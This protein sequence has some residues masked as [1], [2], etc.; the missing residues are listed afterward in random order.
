VKAAHHLAQM[1]SMVNETNTMATYS[2][3][4]F[5]GYAVKMSAH[6]AK[7]LAAHKDVKYIEPNMVARALQCQTFSPPNSWG[8]ARTVIQGPIP[9]SPP[10]AQQP[11]QLR[12]PGADGQG[13]VVHVIDTGI[14]CEHEDFAGGRCTFGFDS[15]REGFFDGNGH[16][17]HV[18]S[19]AVG[20]RFGLARSAT[21]V[22]V[23]VLGSNGSGTF[24]GV[25][26]GIN[27]SA[28]RARTQRVVGNMSLGGG[29]NQAVNDATD[30]SFRA[31]LVMSVAAGNNNAN[32]CN[33]S[34]ASAPLAY[35]VMSTDNADRRSTF[36]SFGTC[37]KI[38]AP[39]TAITAA[40]IGGPT[41]TNTISGTSMAAPHIA[42]I[43]AKWWSAHNT[44]TNQQVQDAISRGANTNLVVNPGA[45]SPNLL[46]LMNCN[47]A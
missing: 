42:G 31:G 29:R 30:A 12:S 26:E 44:W 36:S 35:T 21:T 32:A 33:L 10:I 39:G 11:Y 18:A 2:I 20:A 5:Q 22:A 27:W 4:D 25:I 9:P 28:E 47:S 3:G 19:T 41:R 23:K 24:A 38:F 13:I 46:G 45:G 40:W 34:P 16:G 1:G 8:L 14:Y 15:T 17:T 43:A 6:E 7:S 37:A